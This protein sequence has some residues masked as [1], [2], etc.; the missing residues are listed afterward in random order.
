MDQGQAFIADLSVGR[1]GR[2][3]AML[4]GA[5]LVGKFASPP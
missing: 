4:L 3:V 2:D 5:T 1:I